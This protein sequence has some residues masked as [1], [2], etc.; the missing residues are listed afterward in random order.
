[1]ENFLAQH[2][3]FGTEPSVFLT[4]CGNLMLGWEDA[5]GAVIE[6]ECTPDGYVLFLG[7]S[8]TELDFG[9]DELPRLL[10]LLPGALASD[11]AR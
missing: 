1:M 11:V 7:A 10:G 4:R 9:L 3:G 2:N 8:D 5:E 6:V